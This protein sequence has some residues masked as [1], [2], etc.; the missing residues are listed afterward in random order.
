MRVV[1]AKFGDLFSEGVSNNRNTSSWWKDILL[2]CD[3]LEGI[4]TEW[5]HTEVRKSIGDGKNRSFWDE[6]WV[7]DK[8]LKEKFNCLFNLAVDKEC[9]VFQMGYGCEGYGFGSSIG[10]GSWLSG[11]EN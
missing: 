6:V 1:K 5:I 4:K 2:S 3:K 7:G 10:E 11:K 9:S 8:A